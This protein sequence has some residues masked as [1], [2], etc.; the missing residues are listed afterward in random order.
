MPPNHDALADASQ[1]LWRQIAVRLVADARRLGPGAR[2]PSERALSAQYGVQRGTVQKALDHLVAQ[3]VLTRSPSRGTF[4]ESADSAAPVALLQFHIPS[5][6]DV[7]YA[8]HIHGVCRGL[9]GAGRR[10]LPSL[11]MPNGPSAEMLLDS[12]RATKT[13]GVIVDRFTVPDD[14]PLLLRLHAEF[15]LVSMSKELLEAPAPCAQIEP[16][17]STAIIVRYFVSKGCRSYVGCGRGGAHTI[18]QRRMDAFMTSCAALGAG[19]ARIIA[20]RIEEARGL[21]GELPRPVAVFAPLGRDATQA[22]RIGESLGM[23]LG[24]DLFVG[25]T[26]PDYA[27]DKYPGMALALRDEEQLGCEAA[28]LLLRHIAGKAMPR[29][30]VN[31]PCQVVL[32]E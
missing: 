28:R 21:L 9:E 11:V 32:P 19:P 6:D 31:V 2:F 18:V 12:L 23:C 17:E 22:R 1:P 4:V 14:L 10:L 16:F 29:E 3:R 5:R 20:H 8:T 30:I 13:A 27:R 26:P 7:V 24:Q 15:P 25:A